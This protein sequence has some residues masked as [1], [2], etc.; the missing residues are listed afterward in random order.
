MSNENPSEMDLASLRSTLQQLKTKG[1]L[2]TE[3]DKKI[4]EEIKDDKELEAEIVETED[5]QSN[6]V[7][8]IFQVEKFIELQELNKISHHHTEHEAPA[9]SSINT[10]PTTSQVQTQAPLQNFL[11][12]EAK[13]IHNRSKIPLS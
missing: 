13:T 10:V 9:Q 7:E 1:T 2:L 11:E 6:I 8:K 5:I 12:V 3:L 4:I